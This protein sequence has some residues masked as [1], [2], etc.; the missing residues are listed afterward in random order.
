MYKKFLVTV[1]SILFFALLTIAD[2]SADEFTIT[3]EAE[4]LYGREVH[5]FFDGNYNEAIRIFDKVEYLES[6]DPRPYFFAALAKYRLDKN[7]EEADK[8]FK[9][10]AQLEWES[11][12]AREYDIPEALRRIQGNERLHV[13]KY[14]TQ[15]KINWQKTKTIRD[16]IKYGQQ[17]ENDKKIIADVSK[18][19]VSTAEFGA[20]SPDP[21]HNDKNNHSTNNTENILT[22]II[23]ASNPTTGNPKETVDVPITTKSL[24]EYDIN[25][26][27][28]PIQTEGEMIIEDDDIFAEFDDEPK[29]TPKKPSIPTPDPKPADN[30]DQTPDP[31]PADNP[32]Q[33][34]DPKPADNPTPTDEETPEPIGE[35]EPENNNPTPTT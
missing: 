3:N 12:G 4:I 31:E 35:P 27:T 8:Y 30:P 10:A 21:L 29:P 16:K 5:A 32:D 24:N 6:D 14:R 13:E 20:S 22:D 19:F 18:G 33:T 9:K 7:S 28:G 23:N 26:V 15:A 2:I 17:S 11:K 34:P 25:P 1:T